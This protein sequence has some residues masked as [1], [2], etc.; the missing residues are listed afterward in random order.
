[1]TDS[2][3]QLKSWSHSLW[4][5]APHRAFHWQHGACL[6]FSLSLSLCPS[7]A[8]LHVHSLSLSNQQTCKK[9]NFPVKLQGSW[10]FKFSSK[11]ENLLLSD[12][13][14]IF[15]GALFLVGCILRLWLWALFLQ[16]RNEVCLIPYRGGHSPGDWGGLKWPVKLHFIRSYFLWS[17]FMYRQKSVLFGGHPASSVEHVILDL[18]VV[19]S[20]STLGVEVT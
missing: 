1:M 10:S 2:R 8:G 5:W 20:S 13:M 7:T 19:S 18:G 16:M 14:I 12:W 17:L 4:D 15:L 6:G 3:F 11:Y 9:I